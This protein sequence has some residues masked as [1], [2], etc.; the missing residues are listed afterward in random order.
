[1]TLFEDRILPITLKVFGVDHP[2]TLIVKGNIASLYQQELEQYDRA[3]PLLLECVE[4]RINLQGKT[5][6]STIT[7]MNNLASFYYKRK[8][9][10]QALSLFLDALENIQIT[11]GPQH[12]STLKLLN[13]I[14]QRYI[15]REELDLALSL[16]QKSY[17]QQCV[18][19]GESHS[20][21]EYNTSARKMC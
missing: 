20:V 4:K 3:E 21:Y 9:Y 17:D 1:M 15:L 8:D 11:F 18:V 12:P 10:D 7:A 5:Y 16:L 13:N 2:D 19:F 14:A 6:V